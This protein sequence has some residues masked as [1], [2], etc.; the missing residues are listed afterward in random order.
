MRGALV[1]AGPHRLVYTF[2]PRSFQI[3]L[4]GSILG[5]AAW[6]SLGLF[7]VFRPTHPLLAAVGI[8]R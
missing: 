5:L 8:S 3:G 2:A 7:C 1:S 6:L 4:V